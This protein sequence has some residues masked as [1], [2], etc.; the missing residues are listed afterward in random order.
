VAWYRSLLPGAEL[1]VF[2]ESAHLAHLE[3]RE[4]YNA[5]VRDFLARAE[6]VR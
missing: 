3:E 1:A 5:V 6:R 4:R 2:E